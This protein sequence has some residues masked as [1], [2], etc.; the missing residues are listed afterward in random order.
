M[1]QLGKSIQRK[2]INVIDEPIIDVLNYEKYASAL[3]TL[4]SRTV[5]QSPITVGIYS[6][7]GTGKTFFMSM[8]KKAFQ[9]TDPNDEKYIYINFNCNTLSNPND[10]ININT[11]LL[12]CVYKTVEQ[13]IGKK[14]VYL[15]K[16]IEYN[17]PTT[18]DKI[19]FVLQFCLFM[20]TLA[21]TLYIHFKF[22]MNQ[23]TDDIILSSGLS[24]S[25][26]YLMKYFMYIWKCVMSTTN[27]ALLKKLVKHN[28]RMDIIDNLTD[29]IN[30][31]ISMLN[32][33]NKTIV[34]FID[35][36]ESY[37]YYQI[38]TILESLRILL[39][40]E[41]Y[42]IITFIAMD[43]KYIMHE[44]L[45]CKNHSM[46]LKYEYINRLIQIPFSIPNPTNYVKE[47]ITRTLTQY[48]TEIVEKTKIMCLD[49]NKKHLKNKVITQT[50]CIQ[51]FL[52]LIR[53]RFNY[54]N[55]K[56]EIKQGNMYK[57]CKLIHLALQNWFPENKLYNV[58][59][60]LNEVSE[61][62]STKCLNTNTLDINM[63][64]NDWVDTQKNIIIHIKKPSHT[65]DIVPFKDLVE[66]H[67]I[68]KHNKN[69]Y[70]FEY[71]L[72]DNEQIMFQNLFKFTDGNLRQLKKIMNMYSLSLTVYP[73]S[74]IL[75]ILKLTL[76]FEQWP[77]R[78]GWIDTIIKSYS[79]SFKNIIK[80][81]NEHLN[82]INSINSWTKYHKNAYI[83]D[84]NNI[85]N[86]MLDDVA[87][88]KELSNVNIKV[89]ELFDIDYKKDVFRR[90]L[91]ISP[92]ISIVDYLKY[93][94]KI[95]NIN[96]WITTEIS[97]TYDIID[98][99]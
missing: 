25:T 64:I 32:H 87:K 56:L 26:A 35:N 90:L 46:I 81:N 54:N 82:E 85:L 7:L 31:L 23:L 59:E 24:I 17:L 95:F 91:S 62:L 22:K 72:D 34:L 52:F 29:D 94:P 18:W 79:E 15:F 33:Y 37:D 44:S 27:F 14:K 50:N 92:A 40:H 1:T 21:S 77:C 70:T 86:I 43:P 30:M 69:K 78:M 75:I 63:C 51:I 96:P 71:M 97:N 80:Q 5:S 58:N 3:V 41:K 49:F 53:K 11:D 45:Q 20:V 98:G 60:H 42:P 99:Q 39:T 67:I 76:L 55:N 2:F 89:N 66:N 47:N 65:H 48:N 6:A 12:Y 28:E 73:D 84:V 74:P 57:I 68:D 83:S 38:K 13:S 61:C 36:L 9:I 19:K 10:K 8:I 16:Y 88:N 93:T 4:I